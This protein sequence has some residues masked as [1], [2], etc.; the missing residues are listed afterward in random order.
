MTLENALSVSRGP[1]LLLGQSVLPK[2]P[3]FNYSVPSS[4][5]VAGTELDTAVVGISVTYAE[6]Q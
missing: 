1:G 3:S 5:S 2:S 6:H 4:R